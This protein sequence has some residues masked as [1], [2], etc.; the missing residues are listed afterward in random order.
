M[1][2]DGMSAK[3]GHSWAR[4]PYD[5]FNLS[6]VVV[7]QLGS[8]LPKVPATRSAVGFKE[9]TVV[10]RNSPHQGMPKS[11][12]ITSESLEHAGPGPAD[13]V[14]ALRHTRSTNGSSSAGPLHAPGRRTLLLKE[15][16]SPSDVPLAVTT[17][18][19]GSALDTDV[20]AVSNT[21][22][23][24]VLLQAGSGRHLL[25]G[26]AGDITTDYLVKRGNTVYG[27]DVTI[28]TNPA[29]AGGD[30]VVLDGGSD[31]LVQVSVI[32]LAVMADKS[33]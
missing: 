20:A 18:S 13:S 30:T 33:S 4:Q 19:E 23:S 27:Y 7:P 9:A 22:S 8:L 32:G 6:T 15:A 16:G 17:Y 21:S 24:R 12:N 14:E 28:S 31:I 26:G 3:G 11:F 5:I 2:T 25:Q 10:V 1:H 29:L